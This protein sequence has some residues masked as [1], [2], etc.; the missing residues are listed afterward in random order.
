MDDFQLPSPGEVFW[1]RDPSVKAGRHDWHP[2]LAICLARSGSEV[3]CVTISSNL[4]NLSNLNENTDYEILNEDA[5]PLISLRC[6]ASCRDAKSIP[7]ALLERMFRIK[8]S[9]G[10]LI[11]KGERIPTATLESIVQ[12]LLN[13]DE[14]KRTIKT[15][16]RRGLSD[17]SKALGR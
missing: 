14:V 10:Y 5:H 6:A 8:K 9:K 3:I 16:I 17:I 11:Q 12:K 1:F 7:V 4:Y 2:H 13:S 15:E